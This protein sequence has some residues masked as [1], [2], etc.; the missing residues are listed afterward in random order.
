[1]YSYSASV[2]AIATRVVLLIH[3]SVAVWSV[4][5]TKNGNRWY[6]IL[7]WPLILLVA[8][9]IVCLFRRGRSE[10]KW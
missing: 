7:S 3:A 6:W 4:V 2:K 9:G 10:I 1:M 8:E 5:E